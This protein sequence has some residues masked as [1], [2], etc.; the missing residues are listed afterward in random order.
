MKHSEVTEKVIGC[1]YKVYN[2]LGYGLPERMYVKA[3][4]REFRDVGLKSVVESKHNVFYRGENLGLLVMDLIIDGKVVVEVKACRTLAPEH[5]AQ[6]LSYLA[7]TRFE[8]GLLLGFCQQ[9][10]FKRLVFDNERKNWLDGS[11]QSSSSVRS[12]SP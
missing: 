9:A 11:A 8:V 2:A 5:E 4:R 3:L 1:F 12:V 6:L 10:K 7:G